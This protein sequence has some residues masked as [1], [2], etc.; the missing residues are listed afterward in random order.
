VIGG[1]S[2]DLPIKASR[3]GTLE[4]E[5]PSRLFKTQGKS[6]LSPG[7]LNPPLWALLGHS[8]AVARM[9]SCGGGEVLDLG[10]HKN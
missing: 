10:V 6:G 8:L 7:G 1:L 4:P 5:R 2:T 9:V 3:Y